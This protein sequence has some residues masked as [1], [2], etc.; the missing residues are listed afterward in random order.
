VCGLDC[1]WIKVCP[2]AGSSDHSYENAGSVKRE[3]GSTS[4]LIL[5]F[6]LEVVLEFS[7]GVRG[8]MYFYYHR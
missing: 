7:L 8:V 4:W 1:I 6:K 2:V 3:D 5:T